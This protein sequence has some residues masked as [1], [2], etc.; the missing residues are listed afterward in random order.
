MTIENTPYECGLGKFLQEKIS[1]QCISARVL[2][3]DKIRNPKK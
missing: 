2:N 1:N 3:S